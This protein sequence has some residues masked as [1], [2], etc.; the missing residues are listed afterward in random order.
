MAFCI[1]SKSRLIQLFI[2]PLLAGD[3]TKICLTIRVSIADVINS[4]DINA[5]M[6]L[7]IVT[8]FYKQTFTKKNSHI[9]FPEK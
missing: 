8:Y 1:N 7:I 3:I 2:R 6:Y 9:S 5:G 4:L